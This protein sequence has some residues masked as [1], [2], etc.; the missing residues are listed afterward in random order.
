MRKSVLGIVAIGL[1]AGGL[2]GIMLTRN[3]Q[4]A[5]PPKSSSVEFHEGQMFPTVV[6]P[7]LGD[8]LPGSVAD[9]RAK[10]LILQIFASW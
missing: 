9:F 2:I 7:R 4:Q 8:G 10:K 5:T 1:T 6:L 3:T